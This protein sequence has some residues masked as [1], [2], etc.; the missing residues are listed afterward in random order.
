MPA[1]LLL[2]ILM[3]FCQW[4]NLNTVAQSSVQRNFYENTGDVDF[5]KDDL[6]NA[7]IDFRNIDFARIHAIIFLLTNEVRYR[8][9]LQPLQF[10]PLLENSAAMHAQDMLSDDFFGHLN[11]RHPEKK[12]PNDRASLCGVTNPFLAE[13]IIEGYGLR[14]KSNETVYLRG[15]GKFSSTPD[16]ELI[17]PHTYLSFGE[18][19]IM[20][21]M[22]SKDHRKNILASEALQLGCGVAFYFD[23]EFN[24]MPSFKAV[25]NF[26]WYHL[27]IP[28]NH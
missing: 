28:S 20:G 10:S 8:N 5:R 23:P 1:Q 2:L 16:G 22:N 3:I 4:M 19:L 6:F 17:K 18:S 14:Y 21:W 13:N 25:Q 24:D 15:K 27:I 7:E 26:Q 11:P 12:T 9:H